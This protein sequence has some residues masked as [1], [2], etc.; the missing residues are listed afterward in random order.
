MINYSIGCFYSQPHQESFEA[1]CLE[2]KFPN[3]DTF[4]G[5]IRRMET[6]INYFLSATGSALYILGSVLLIPDIALNDGN[7]VY[8]LASV[9]IMFAQSWKIYRQGKSVTRMLG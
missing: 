8:I 5:K 2:N 7:Y 1:Y 9:V 3:A 6:G 4:W